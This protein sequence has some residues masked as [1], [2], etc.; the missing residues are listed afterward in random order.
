M[1]DGVKQHWQLLCAGWMDTGDVCKTAACFL[2]CFEMI[3]PTGFTPLE[4]PENAITN[5]R[6]ILCYLVV[7]CTVYVHS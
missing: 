6:N 5:R 3:L 4:E 7:D 1:G 2:E